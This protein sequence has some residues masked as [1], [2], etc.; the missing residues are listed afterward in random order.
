[1][2]TK[3]KLP[4]RQRQPDSD[5]LSGFARGTWHAQ[6]Q[7]DAV[8]WMGGATRQLLRRTA[9]LETDLEALAKNCSST[10][11]KLKNGEDE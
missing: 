11:P 9:K 2:I 8:N 10:R 1:M 7:D 5:Q 6:G 3:D 4:R